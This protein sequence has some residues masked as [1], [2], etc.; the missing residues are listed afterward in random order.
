[1]NWLTKLF[2]ARAPL[3]PIADWTPGTLGPVAAPAVRTIHDVISDLSAAGKDLGTVIEQSKAVQQAVSDKRVLI[4]TLEDEYN[5]LKAGF[6][7]VIA[8][9]K[10]LV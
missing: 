10:A 9:M 3:T 5:G 1:M 6:E 8:A 4:A 7:G 2:A